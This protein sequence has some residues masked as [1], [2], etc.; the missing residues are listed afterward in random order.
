[1]RCTDD[2]WFESPPL[3]LTGM[4]GISG[5]GGNA[6]ETFYLTDGSGNPLLAS[7]GAHD[8]KFLVHTGAT[9]VANVNI[10]DYFASL[11]DAGSDLQHS[12]AKI[13]CLTEGNAVVALVAGK[14]IN[15][16]AYAAEDQG[17]QSIAKPESSVLRL[18]NQTIRAANMVS[19]APGTTGALY[20]GVADVV[21][22]DDG[23]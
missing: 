23:V 6:G 15:D 22:W 17:G 19:A 20:R 3:G 12:G 21:T 1:M 18:N 14:S 8:G 2:T 9:N 4:S 16:L 10:A 7:G 11:P 5:I 13:F